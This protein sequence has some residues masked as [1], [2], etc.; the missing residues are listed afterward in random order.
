MI[1]RPYLSDD[2]IMQLDRLEAKRFA[3]KEELRDLTEAVRRLK[4][5]GY[6]RGVKR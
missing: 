4:L 5:R 6:Q 1:Y 2:E 3:L